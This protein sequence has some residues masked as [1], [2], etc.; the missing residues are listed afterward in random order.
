MKDAC[1]VDNASGRDPNKRQRQK[2]DHRD[3][4]AIAIIIGFM[5]PTLQQRLAQECKTYRAKIDTALE[6]DPDP[7]TAYDAFVNWTLEHYPQ[8]QIAHS[9]LLELLEEATRKFKDDAAYRGDLRYLKLWAL[10]ASHVEDASV[11][12]TFLFANGIGTMYALT[13]WEYAAALERK[14][15]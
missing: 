11:V 12:Y 7:L 4:L 1:H 13:Y 2:R 10:Y 14:G 6:E 15:K 5:D 8:D 3:L 9:G